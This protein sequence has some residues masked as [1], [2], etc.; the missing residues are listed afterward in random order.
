MEQPHRLVRLPLLITVLLGL[1]WGE[2]VA[3]SPAAE[4][5]LPV[6][7]RAGFSIT[8]RGVATNL[9]LVSVF[10]LPGETLEIGCSSGQ[11]RQGVTVQADSGSAS[12]KGVGWQWI[13]PSQP[14]FYDLTVSREAPADTIRLR[15][16]VMYPFSEIKNGRLNGY[17][18]GEYP[19]KPY[20]GLPQY[21]PPRGFVEVTPDNADV[22][23]TPHFRLGQF[24]CKQDGDFPK[25]VALRELLLLKLELIL[26]RVNQAG[27]PCS[28]FAVLSGYRTP[29]YNKSIGNVKYSRHLWGGA[30][31]IF[32][33]ENPVD[34]IMDDLNRDG[35]INWKDA[36]IVYEIIDDMYGTENYKR[37]VGGLARYRKT[38]AHGPFVH[39]DVRGFRARW[40]D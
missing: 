20:R 36:A 38:P 34:G 24:L 2:A 5:R 19:R 39:V 14:G 37:F 3:V 35:H 40:G 28:T 16:F 13:A 9:K 10:V 22:L 6:P 25:Y 12:E 31:D 27:Y 33:D 18:I 4:S 17:H 8:A 11:G 15:A 26:E 30:A 7:A 1:L 29:W 21:R 23:L 32:I